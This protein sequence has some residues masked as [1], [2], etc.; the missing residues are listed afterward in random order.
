MGV[1]TSSLRNASL[2]LDLGNARD[3]RVALQIGAEDLNDLLSHNM[4]IV[5]SIFKLLVQTILRLNPAP[6]PVIATMESLRGSPH[7]RPV[8]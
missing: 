2:R 7:R 3:L 5:F 8:D 1:V 4:E 6:G